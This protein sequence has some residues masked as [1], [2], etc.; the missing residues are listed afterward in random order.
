M[1]LRLEQTDPGYLQFQTSFHGIRA[2]AKNL[3]TYFRVRKLQTPA[4]II[5][6]WA[7]ESDNNPTSAY[8]ATVAKALGV[9][10]TDRIDLENRDVML[11]MIKVMIGVEC[12][13][14]P[15]SDA[16]LT[17]AIKSA[18]DSHT[19]AL[20]ASSAPPPPDIDAAPVTHPRPVPPPS[21]PPVSPPPGKT[22]PPLV[23][24]PTPIPTRK[25]V[26]GG[27]AGA[28]AFVIM[29]LW[30]KYLPGAPIPAEYATEI[31]GLVIL[32]VTL[33][34]QYFVKNRAT[35]IPPGPTTPEEKTG[36]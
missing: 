23:D 34:T 20:D 8:V 28:V 32:A 4:A 24:Q 22:T 10:P 16:E 6:R 9:E 27:A 33:V 1:G 31:A 29:I 19:A 15:F 14:Q 3:L 13:Q 18:Y 12:G 25:V 5:N 36:P 30:N 35:D 2:A 17:I 21:P 11:R 26:V 7:P